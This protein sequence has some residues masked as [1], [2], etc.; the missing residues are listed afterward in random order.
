MPNPFE[1]TIP[2]KVIYKP[3]AV[4]ELGSLIAGMNVQKALLV[5][6][7]ILTEAGYAEQVEKILRSGGVAY[8][9]FNEVEP[10]PSV[11]TVEKGVALFRD[12]DY[13]LVIALGGGSPIDVAKAV[14]VRVA[15]DQS[16]PSLEGLEQFKNDPLAV[17]AIPSTAGS[18][19]EVTPFSV[20][21]D[22]Q[23]KYKFTIFSSRI[24][25]RIAILDPG[26]I[27][28]LPAS[29]AASTGLDALTHAVESYTS[30]LGSFYSDAFAEKA[31]DL[32]GKHLRRFVASR[33]NEEAAGAM[34]T[35]ASFAGLAFA[36]G[37]LGIAHAMAHPL[38]AHFGVP[39]GVANAILLPHVMEYNLTAVPE[40]F[41]RVS[42]LLGEKP[43]AENAISAIRKLNRD[44]GIAAS[45]S[46]VGVQSEA[47]EAMTADAMKS[48][49][50]P[51]NPRLTGSSE[52]QA[53]YR[54]AM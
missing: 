19:S 42:Q 17:I 34:L 33:E 9:M 14:A 43:A 6:D 48:G 28:S 15:N 45:L 50:V 23:K 37:R 41:E 31:V 20:I 52:I 49:N 12:L 35:A 36:H 44:L 8:Q 3:G 1:F 21:T 18:G 26:L 40:K 16:T 11:E 30:L 7:Q 46:E 51:A 39:H 53:L 22:R 25:P 47:I 5:T 2:T 27:S 29:V 38:S 10:N 54:Q 4:R 32:I 13:Q 24:I